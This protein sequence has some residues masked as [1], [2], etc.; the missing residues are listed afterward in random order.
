MCGESNRPAFWHG[1]HPDT[2][3][4]LEHG[5]QTWIPGLGWVVDSMRMA[6]EQ[7]RGAVAWDP[8]EQRWFARKAEPFYAGPCQHRRRDASAMRP[9]CADCHVVLD[10]EP[11]PNV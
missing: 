4:A 11:L 2:A 10:A 8:V 3:L 9:I 5:W 7:H 6:L 1:Q